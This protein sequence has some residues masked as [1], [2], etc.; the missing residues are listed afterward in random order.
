MAKTIDRFVSCG[1]RVDRIRS[2]EGPHI[3]FAAHYRGSS[4]LFDSAEKLL[5]WIRWP[6]NTSYGQELLSWIDNPPWL[7]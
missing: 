4:R 6:K 5:G 3:T 7:A 1:L 2:H